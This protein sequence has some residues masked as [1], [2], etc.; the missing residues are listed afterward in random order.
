MPFEVQLLTFI[1]VSVLA[2]GWLVAMLWLA[3]SKR[4]IRWRR[5][6]GLTSVMF[7]TAVIL[8]ALSVAG[9][10]LGL[11][12]VSDALFYLALLSALIGLVMAVLASR[13]VAIWQS[14][15][16][17]P[18]RSRSEPMP[19]PKSERIKSTGVPALDQLLLEPL[20]RT[21]MLIYGPEGTHPWRLAQ[22][23]IADGL[24]KGEACI[25]VATTRPPE[26]VL[27]QLGE[28]F[29]QKHGRPL[30]KFKATFGIVDCFTPFASFSEM[31]AFPQPADYA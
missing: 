7:F 2:V 10:M 18:G 24:M 11:S 17:A 9:L 29:R 19:K 25:Y 1:S 3:D 12:V 13:Q 28:L 6:A 30:E 5:A 8:S 26:L 23:F 27:E 15:E 21:S 22:H 31:D 14:F 4:F 20:P 16:I